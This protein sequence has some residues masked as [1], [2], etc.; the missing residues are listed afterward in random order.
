MSY[1]QINLLN[2]AA[3]LQFQVALFATIGYCHAYIHSRFRY[4]IL[5]NQLHMLYELVVCCLSMKE[6]ARFYINVIKY[7]TSH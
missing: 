3:S 4:T 2:F 6:F 1:Q 5:G 7:G